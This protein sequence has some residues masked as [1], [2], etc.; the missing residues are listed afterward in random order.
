MNNEQHNGYTNYATW[1]VHCE[2]LGNIDFTNH[3]EPS[4]IIGIVEDVV[5]TNK[6]QGGYIE[7]YA[8]A[9]L[10]QVNFNEIAE[11]INDQED[12]KTWNDAPYGDDD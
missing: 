10:R 4:D 7:D 1:R 8:R 6:A 3:V 5:F 11:L 9:F 12:F 2:I